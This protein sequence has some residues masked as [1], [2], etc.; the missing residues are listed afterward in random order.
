VYPK[1]LLYE[2][3][4]YFILKSDKQ[5]CGL[6]GA[7]GTGKTTLVMQL[8]Y[9]LKDSECAIYYYD[10]LQYTLQE[11]TSDLFSEVYALQ[12]TD[13]QKLIILDN[14]GAMHSFD[15]NLGF[16]S[17]VYTEDSVFVPK[18]K[19]LVISN[20]ERVIRR[21]LNKYFS[22]EGCDCVILHMCDVN[23]TEY[24]ADR[25]NLGSPQCMCD[26]KN[27]RILNYGDIENY[28]GYM[29]NKMRMTASDY[30]ELWLREYYIL[31]RNKCDL[32]GISAIPF[33][34]QEFMMDLLYVIITENDS[35]VQYKKVCSLEF[36]KFKALLKLLVLTE[37][38]GFE[39][40]GLQITE[41]ELYNFLLVTNEKI[42]L[43]F[44]D[45]AEKLFQNFRIFFRSIRAIM[46]TINSL[47]RL[48]I[49]FLLKID[50]F[51]KG[52]SLGIGSILF[53]DNLIFKEEYVFV[54]D[55]NEKLSYAEFLCK[56]ELDIYNKIL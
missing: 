49:S 46:F 29:Q 12:R 54:L 22:Y 14:F 21:D 2:K 7:Y 32:R 5:V 23:F 40:K 20:F 33:Y 1:R 45:T 55:T 44:I 16:F 42:S 31:E 10:A 51:L 9:D 26:S 34:D 8:R 47:K 11:K 36:S 24:V 6:L 35:S 38:I 56:A 37:F 41:K 27:L 48:G 4:K 28:I 15:E 25:R 17:D 30:F 52:T 3:L 19:L 43:N 39:S 53:R 13:E 50:D 18:T